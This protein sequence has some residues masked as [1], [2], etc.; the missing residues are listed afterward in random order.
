MLLWELCISLNCVANEHGTWI[1]LSHGSCSNLATTPSSHYHD[2][3]FLLEQ[4]FLG[5]SR[6]PT[7]LGI[8]LFSCSLPESDTEMWG[9]YFKP[10]LHTDTGVNLGFSNLIPDS[11]LPF[12][13][14]Y[15]GHLLFPSVE[16]AF[17]LRWY[18]HLSL[19]GSDL[20]FL[21]RLNFRRRFVVEI[22]GLPWD[23]I[24]NVPIL[25]HFSRSMIP[26]SRRKGGLWS[27]MHV[28]GSCQ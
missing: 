1:S 19:W 6:S 21:W 23:P 20:V 5:L 17:Y 2:I 18:L 26:E 12:G 27:E 22:L 15:R 11:H 9:S 3:C 7:N 16:L 13:H 10:F 8:R 24:S 25:K 14:N 4:V 28:I